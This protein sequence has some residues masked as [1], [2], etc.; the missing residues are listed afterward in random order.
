MKPSAEVDQFPSEDFGFCCKKYSFLKS[1]LQNKSK[2][3]TRLGHLL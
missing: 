2:Q 3:D 1:A